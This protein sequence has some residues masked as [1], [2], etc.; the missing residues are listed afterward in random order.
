MTGQGRTGVFCDVICPD[1]EVRPSSGEKNHPRG[2]MS[3][4][5]GLIKVPPEQKS[6]VPRGPPPPQ[7]QISPSR[8]MRMGEGH[9]HWHPFFTSLHQVPP[10]IWTTSKC[11]RIRERGFLRDFLPRLPSV[12]LRDAFLNELPWWYCAWIDAPTFDLQ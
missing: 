1:G 11:S 6:E 8:E 5:G 3:G 2:L 4:S 9:L 12:L 10:S 7:G